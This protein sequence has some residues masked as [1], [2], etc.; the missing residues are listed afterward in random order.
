MEDVKDG[1]EA[2]PSQSVQVSVTML[3]VFTD[4]FT[5]L[6]TEFTIQ[7]QTSSLVNNFRVKYKVMIDNLRLEV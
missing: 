6:F 5:P 7:Q 3:H 4:K 1:R 2:F